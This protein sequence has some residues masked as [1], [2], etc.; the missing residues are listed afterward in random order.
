MPFFF[1]LAGWD[2][3]LTVGVGAASLDL[4]FGAMFQEDRAAGHKEA[5]PLTH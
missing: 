3:D 1:L 4:G 5:G 2:A